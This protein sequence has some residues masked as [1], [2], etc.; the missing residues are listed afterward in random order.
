MQIS[1]YMAR[2]VALLAAALAAA[3]VLGAAAARPAGGGGGVRSAARARAPLVVTPEAHGAAGDGVVDDSAAL[4]AA[5][6]SCASA[7][8]AGC[9]VV[10]AG[11]Y[12]SGPVVLNSS[13]TT[14]DV[15]GALLMLPRGR[16]PEVPPLPLV[17]NARPLR[18]LRLTGGGTIGNADLARALE[19]WGCKLSGCWRPHLAVLSAVAGVR[20]DGGLTFLNAP[21]HN[22][23]LDNCSA[24]RVDGVRMEA[25]HLSPNTDGINFYGGTD[26]AFTN[27]AV[28][29]GD[30]CVSV[31]PVGEWSAPCVRAADPRGEECRGGDV[32]VENVT[33]VGG[34]GLA[35]GGVRHGTVSNVTFRNVS[36]A[37]A[38]GDTQGKFSPGGARLKAYPNG[39]GS[40]HSILY[41]DLAVD[42]VH[43]PL[44]LVGHYCPWPCRTPDGNHSVAFRNV[45]FRR[46]R[47]AGRRR[48]Q[49]LFECGAAAPCLA[50][51]GV[52][53]EDVVLGG[54]DARY[55]CNEH[56]RL[57]FE[58]AGRQ[59]PAACSGEAV[60]L[61]GGGGGGGGA[62]SAP[63]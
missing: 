51:G 3:A 13:G 20:I 47:G 18:D 52:V 36:V 43:T 16:Y 9:R 37:G 11:A 5:V 40:V 33:C 55:E 63:S 24:A 32:L 19:W 61:G 28:S 38:P 4:S 39:T 57:D 49:G 60:G 50:P 29:N 10:L 45:T 27:S 17:S 30:D 59:S 2:R 22:V 23:E 21:N 6:A 54:A 44:S 48:T 25:P 62:A 1:G 8:P 34:H 41:E 56:T 12:L 26:Q 7:G 15:R 58:G 31:V 14:L 35:V 53:L 46:V 42:G